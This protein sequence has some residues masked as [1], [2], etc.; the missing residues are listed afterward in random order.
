MATAT[1]VPNATSGCRRFQHLGGLATTY[2]GGGSAT[3]QDACGA[4]FDSAG[5]A[6][7]SRIVWWI[8]LILMSTGLV[9]VDY[10][11]GPL[12]LFPITFSI[13]VLL[14]ARRFG[15]LAATPFAILLPMARVAFDIL[16]YHEVFPLTYAICN[17][18][19]AT[20]VFLTLACL[21]DIV[22][23]QK[24]RLDER[25]QLLE[26]ILPICA[27]CKKIRKEDGTWEAVESY[28]AA[29]SQAQFSHG[30][31]EECAHRHYPE[32]YGLAK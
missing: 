5:G 2:N 3:F 4:W 19:I 31:C 6:M 12:I 25:V 17:A 26:G 27:F 14:A 18:V 1:I 23:Q 9:Y 13:P 8:L 11:T 28:V 10:L 21:L 15:I 20:V 24:R 22:V 7:K 16:I 30:I 32:A 29:R